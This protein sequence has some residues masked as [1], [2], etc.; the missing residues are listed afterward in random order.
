[1]RPEMLRSTA[2]KSGSGADSY[3][4]L[5]ALGAMSEARDHEQLADR[6]V[7][8]AWDLVQPR[9]LALIVP[10]RNGGV[11]KASLRQDVTAPFQR[12][13]NGPESPLAR[14]A[15]GLRESGSDAYGMLA[16][17]HWYANKGI[18]TMQ[19]P[20]IVLLGTD[21]PLPVRWAPLCSL[22]RI[23]RNLRLLLDESQRD[24]LT[25]LRNRRTLLDSLA[26]CLEIERRA[27]PSAPGRRIETG[28][29]ME[30]W[31]AVLDIDHFK[32]VNDRFGHVFGDEV[33][34]LLAR[35][36]TECFRDNDLL[37][38]VGGEEFVVA[39]RVPGRQG[40]LASLERFRRAVKSHRFP[41]VGTVT[42]S[43]GAAR[44]A[45]IGAPTD[46]FD[47]AD[48]ALYR[49]KQAGRDRITFYE[50]FRE[51]EVPVHETGSVE[52]FAHAPDGAVR[53]SNSVTGALA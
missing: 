6:F 53:E 33:L 9:A 5:D 15:A 41:Q 23:Y 40:A 10:D 49:S 34:V 36:M 25:G 38:R 22:A 42:V 2:E 32:R 44:I 52:L 50:D 3:A 4:L 43:I 19:S 16:G 39:L 45:D 30:Y 28:A 37:F 17:L 51:N 8:A 24:K 14:L 48:K 35:L 7:G 47:R 12:M 29:D 46:M 21:R 26:K 1:M 18:S 11:A 20:E 31:L 13:P 27:L